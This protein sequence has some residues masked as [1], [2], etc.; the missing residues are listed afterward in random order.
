MK[1]SCR[2][3]TFPTRKLI[4][5]IIIIIKH[6]RCI[7]HLGLDICFNE[8]NYHDPCRRVLYRERNWTFLS[9]KIYNFFVKRTFPIIWG[10]KYFF[11]CSLLFN[12]IGPTIW[13]NLPSGIS[14]YVTSLSPLVTV[15]INLLVLQIVRADLKELN[16]IDLYGAPYAYTPFCDS[17]KEMDGFRYDMQKNAINNI[18]TIDKCMFSNFP[19]F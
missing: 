6:G 16:D 9:F 1:Q 18:F 14:H 17:R 3:S 19:S 5:I 2:E 13:Y 4:I 12:E 11:F 8:Y 10:M 15:V 7:H